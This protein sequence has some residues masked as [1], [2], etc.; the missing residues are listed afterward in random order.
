M[1]AG[2]REPLPFLA[3]GKLFF[4]LNDE[5]KTVRLIPDLHTLEQT[6]GPGAPNTRLSRQQTTRLPAEVKDRAA[7]TVPSAGRKQN[8]TAAG[9]GV[10]EQG[11]T[12]HLQTQRQRQGATL[13]GCLS[14]VSLLSRKSSSVPDCRRAPAPTNTP[15][16]QSIC[17]GS[18]SPPMSLPLALHAGFCRQTLDSDVL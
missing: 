16:N 1:L 7:G 11:R 15:Q 2:V 12:F 10:F 13:G 6:Y 14:A 3:A 5:N 9:V 17:P 4:F 18:Q 8:S